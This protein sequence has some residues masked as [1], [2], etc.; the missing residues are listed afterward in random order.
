MYKRI[1]TIIFLFVAQ[2]QFAQF[3]QHWTIE[4][5]NEIK[6]SLSEKKNVPYSDN[7]EMS[8]KR[9]S[10]IVSYD[11]DK[12][13]QLSV[14]RQIFF[15]QLRTYIKTN[16]PDWK[17]YRAY[18]ARTYSDDI[19]PTLIVN[20]KIYSPGAVKDVRINGTLVIEHEPEEGVA[21]IRTFFPSTN[22]R[23]FIEQW[24]L[25]NTTDSTIRLLGKTTQTK[26]HVKG[27]KGEY[28]IN[29]GSNIK[30]NINLAG[31][32]SCQFSVHVSATLNEEPQL[33]VHEDEY[34]RDRID[35][36]NKM[37]SSLQL[38]TP[39]ST[40]NT[41]FEFSKIR[42]SESIFESKL[43]LVHSPGGGRYYVGFWANDQAEYVNPFFPY[44]GY[45]LGNSAALNM[46]DLYT[47]EITP[48]Y[49]NIRYS[50][51]MEGDAPISPLDRGDAAMIA[52]GA[53]QFAMA[54]GDKE[55][56][57]KIW[58]LIKWCLEYNKRNLNKSGVVISESDEMEGRIET[59]NA[60][61]ST[62]SLYYGALNLAADLGVSLG[63]PKK[64]VSGYRKA[65]VRLKK[66]IE[67]YFGETIDGLETYK[68]YKEH[69]NLR[70]W[71]CLPL[72]VQIFDRKEG[73]IDALFDR[74]WTDNG[75]HVEKNDE[76]LEIS[77]VFWD[78]G[79]LY[80][81]RGTFLAGATERSLNK[82]KEFSKKRLLGDRVPYVVEAYPEGNMAHLS[83]ESGLYCRVF[84]E[85]M[86]GMVPTGLS[87]FRCTPRLPE[88]WNK[89]ELN[90]IKAF[91]KDFHI[92]V[93]REGDKIRCKVVESNGR[94]FVNSLIK[95]GDSVEVFLK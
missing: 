47:K 95:D 36:L 44:L 72:V 57:E 3:S 81:L 19:L 59:G 34:Y 84:T 45:E 31:G 89:M 5:T 86:F 94:V 75:V 53:A 78:R 6:L 20:E 54:S 46:Y 29:T 56:A 26:R 33:I 23:L 18:L 16:D 69:E 90:H 71:I 92:K 7:I 39:D 48:D 88:E 17:H 41:L 15:P 80:A 10:A 38:V 58:P 1:S 62:S 76:N 77:K 21:L 82:L 68:Y 67:A 37:K 61:L 50:F 70:H 9:V 43:G 14:S 22:Q 11:I 85:G 83:A 52:Y 2:F 60:N 51:E 74:L 24:E 13:K 32:E 42:A 66:N 8:G 63:R 79:T 28:V 65:A 93:L 55:V 12:Q 64:E 25:I 4:N 30:E 49:R 40:L 91:N 27:V 87:S 73:T 35:F